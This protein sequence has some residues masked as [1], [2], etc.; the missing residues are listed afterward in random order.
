VL[1]DDGTRGLTIIAFL[2][3]VFS[4]YYAWA[5]RRGSGD[6]MRHCAMNVAL[7]GKHKRWAMTER[8]SGSVQRGTDFLSIGPSMMSW[9]GS[10]LTVRIDEMAVPLPRRIRGTIRLRP[11]AIETRTIALDTAGHH[12]WRPIAPC[13]RAEVAFDEPGTS[14]SGQAY[15]D[16]NNGDRP[17]ETDFIRWDWSRTRVPGGTVILYDV[18]RRDSPLALAMRYDDAGGIKDFVAAAAISLPPTRWQLPRRISAASPSL[19]KTLEDT[20]FYSR[21]L[22]NAE[23]FGDSVTAIH[24][25]LALDR[26][27]APW[28]QAM[29]PFRMPRRS[30]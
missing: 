19:S 10:E 13:A 28:V 24:E 2:G 22:I 6:P 30:E 20:P 9:D 1:S 26:F 16:T 8:S 23:M 18:V 15:F 14:W 11:S 7:Y 25:S 27:T 12:R 4:P 29:L 5:R 3:S 21:S 17:L